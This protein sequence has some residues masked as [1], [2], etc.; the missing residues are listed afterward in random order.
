MDKLQSFITQEI[1]TKFG[2][3]NKNKSKFSFVEQKW[4]GKTNKAEF[5]L[6]GFYSISTI[7]GY[8]MPNPFYT[9]I[10]NTYGLMWFYGISTFIGYLMLNTVYTYILKIHILVWFYGI[11]TIVGYLM[12]NPLYTYILKKI[13]LGLVLWHINYCRL[14]NAKSFLY[15]YIEYIWFDLVLWHIKHCRLFN[16]KYCLYIYIKKYMSWS[17][18]MANHPL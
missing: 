10:L 3:K 15:I 1:K 7:V 14:F 9:N 5:A 16:V 17:G 11:S 18:F 2:E 6:V 4:H 8:L 13:C 12:P